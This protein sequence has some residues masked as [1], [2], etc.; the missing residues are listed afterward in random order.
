[1]YFL[2][3][4]IWVFLSP[5]N[6]LIIFLL[7]GFFLKQLNFKIFSKFIFIFCFCF[8]IIIGFFPTGQFLLFKLEHQ[9]QPL[10]VLPKEID[11]LIVL[12][13]PSSAGLTAIY[14]QVHFNDG[15]ERLTE[16]VLVIKKNQ[17]RKIIFSGGSSKQNFESS[18]AFVAKKFFHEMGI[19]TNNIYFE[20]KSRNTYEN[21]LY[22]KKIINPKK[23]EK[24]I[25][26]TSSF[27]MLRAM[28]VSD[29]LEWSLIPYPVDYRTA[30]N[31]SGFRFSFNLLNNINNF[32]LALHEYVGLVSYYL[33]GRTNEIL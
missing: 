28:K 26:I 20:Y 9:Y 16:A 10:E 17:P 29:K 1:M 24:W 21:I 15:G 13:G 23:N 7:F 27:H 5:L 11:G 18:H 2:S 19:N 12:G 22:S 33:L 8:F 4:F 14:D 6:F 32:D 25:I 30:N 3:K 31:F